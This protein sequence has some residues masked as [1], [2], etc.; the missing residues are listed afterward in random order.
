[1][2]R[3]KTFEFRRPSRTFQKSIPVFFGTFFLHVQ[4]S[5]IR[6][7]QIDNRRQYLFCQ[8]TTNNDFRD[9]QILNH[10]EVLAFQKGFYRIMAFYERQQFH[11]RWAGKFK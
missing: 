6:R 4:K 2:L 9:V 1:M 5:G 7:G 10:R 11:F 3:G 8:E